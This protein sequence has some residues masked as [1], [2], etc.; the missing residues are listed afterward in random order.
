MCVCVLLYVMCQKL[1]CL[2]RCKYP[3]DS[4][5]QVGIFKSSKYPFDSLCQFGIFTA[6][7]YPFDSLSLGEHFYGQ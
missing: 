4:L 2:T 1:E 5:C 3:F 7:K 6:S